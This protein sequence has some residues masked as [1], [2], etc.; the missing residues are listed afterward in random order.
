MNQTNAHSFKK[1]K[2]RSISRAP[3]N[4]SADDISISWSNSKNET[5]AKRLRKAQDKNRSK[6]ARRHSL[7]PKLLLQSEEEDSATDH[8]TPGDVK[9]Q[10]LRFKDEALS[11][12]IDLGDMNAGAYDEDTD[13][14]AD[15]GQFLNRPVRIHEF[16]WHEN[17]FTQ[18]SIRPW[19]LYFNTTQIK[20][21]LDNFGRISCRLH[22][23]FVLNAS[24]FYFGSLRAC[25]FP[26]GD[27]RSDYHASADQV[28]FSQVPGVYLEPQSMSSAELV[29]P[30]LW[31]RNWLDATVSTDFDRM[32]VLQ[33]LQYAN[34][35]S[36]N[37][38][39]GVG[40]TVAVYAWAEDVR[41]MGPTT[42]L[43][44]Q[45]EE[46]S[47]TIS[48]PATMV[49]NVASRLTDVPVI[50][51]FATAT[52]VG[53]KAVASIAK[54]FGYSNPPM[55]G[56]VSGVHPKTFHAFA[57]VE[58]RMPID[59]LSVDP[60]N[61]VTISSKAAGVDEE[62]PLAFSNLLTRESFL[63]GT[64]WSENLPVDTLIFSAL[65]NPGY[66][67]GGG[68]YFTTPPMS[69]FSQGFRLWRGSLVYK[70]RFIKTKYH[71]GRVLISWDPCGDI[72]TNPD[73][74]TTTFS[75]IVDISLE[76]EVE[77]IVPYRATSPWLRPHF[78]AD[79]SSNGPA[80]TYTYN[81]EYHNGVI[82]MR[83]Q[84]IITAPAL[85]AEI[86]V[87][88]YVRAGDD[89]MFSAP[90]DI[91]TGYT[92]KDPTGVIQ[93]GEEDSITMDPTS[94]DSHVAS[95]T[96][97]EV[98]CSMRPILHRASLGYIQY[99]GKPVTAAPAGL[100]HTA[101]YIY[102]V[103]F[104]IGRS[105]IGYGYATVAGSGVRYNFAPNHPI[106]WTI[107]CFVGY[108]G[109]T[110][111]HVNTTGLG[112]NITNVPHLSIAR[113]YDN[114]IVTSDV[115]ANVDQSSNTIITG[116]NLS[117]AAIRYSSGY[118]A[119]T[120]TGQ[121]G[122]SLTNTQ[123]QPACSVNIPQY[124]RYRFYPAFASTRG[125]D[126]HTNTRYNDEAVV[127]CQ[128]NVNEIVTTESDW[129][130]LAYY[131]SAGVDFQPIFFLCTPRLFTTDLPPARD[132]YP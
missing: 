80:P 118:R 125:I 51:T 130:S 21:K 98:I 65:V 33:F 106:D 24:P 4:G 121:L 77:V 58:T 40:I 54:L 9:T 114:P 59:K 119:I 27:Q 43:A 6:P 111:I 14:M 22:L 78:R 62:D 89:F 57:N 46:T 3:I 101:N 69:Y 15:L 28:P 5:N 116:N 42:L 93:S 56:D 12:K 53:A 48:A 49:A 100:Y 105:D 38:A 82:T 8:A 34:L 94:V 88:V 35:R 2:S 76:D 55:I 50:G 84:S 66:V 7:N 102:R 23:K 90:R 68:G 18:S 79:N 99:A 71:K 109:S 70:F 16:T 85:A 97:G 96:T 104:G 31:P 52:S 129:P 36:A 117:R 75:R 30:F 113:F 95:I 87:L 63:L 20:K 1:S 103:P 17:T 127:T 107:N 110:N 120:Q 13:S 60:K 41:I 19:Q 44:L 91:P 81:D 25:Y 123:G 47:G 64:L 45:S 32:G 29:L 61:E 132:V 92:V 124:S 73:T 37:G 131:Y 122:M 86:D 74:E 39:T 26:L 126:P 72:S 115:M 128:F 10:N 11:Q 112:K 67:R 108:R 83:V